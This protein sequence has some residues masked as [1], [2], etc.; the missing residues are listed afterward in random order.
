MTGSARI[1]VRLPRALAEHAHGRKDLALTLPV[2]ARLHD[3]IDA[4]RTEAPAVARRVVDETGEVRRFVNVYVGDD[5][6]RT[7][8]G[9]DTPVHDGTVVF[10]IGSVAGG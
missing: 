9:L 6:C 1:S 2:D 7:L 8:Q 3:V 4:L 10:I 5:E